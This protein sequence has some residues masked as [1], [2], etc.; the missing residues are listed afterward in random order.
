MKKELIGKYVSLF[1]VNLLFSLQFLFLASIFLNSNFYQKVDKNHISFEFKTQ[2]KTTWTLLMSNLDDEDNEEPLKHIS[3]QAQFC[4]LKSIVSIQFINQN[5][6]NNF[7][8][9][10]KY[11]TK[12]KLERIVVKFFFR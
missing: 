6:N 4:S 9:F 2:S 12:R 10:P 7:F 8:D 11:Q 1:T 5:A 3:K